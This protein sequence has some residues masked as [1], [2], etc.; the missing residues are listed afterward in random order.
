MIFARQSETIWL[1]CYFPGMVLHSFSPLT[2][3]VLAL[4]SIKISTREH[5]HLCELSQLQFLVI[6][7][8]D[9]MIQQGSFPKLKRIVEHVQQG[10]CELAKKAGEDAQFGDGI[11]TIPADELARQLQ[12]FAVPEGFEVARASRLSL[13]TAENGDEEEDEDED[14]SKFLGLPGEANVKMISA[15]LLKEVKRLRKEESPNYGERH[16]ENEDDANSENAEEE[17]EPFEEDVDEKDEGDEEEEE[18]E[19]SDDEESDE[20]KEEEESGCFPSVHRQ[21]FVYSATLTLPVTANFKGGRKRQRTTDDI[22]STISE[23]V[24]RS[25]TPGNRTKVVDLSFKE[26]PTASKL[27]QSSTRKNEKGAEPPKVKNLRLPP[28]L[29][30]QEIKCVKLHK[31]S[32]LY[33]Y[34]MATPEGTAGSALVFCNS[35]AAV[36]RVGALLTKLRLETRM[37]HAQMQQVRANHSFYQ[38]IVQSAVRK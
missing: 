8:V 14:M 18:E 9:R 36:K 24:E 4:L 22:D 19:G 21:V 12:T 2:L 3:L 31:D 7:E 37:L 29:K 20:G 34:L 35:I 33:T 28:G 5:E 11:E 16:D 27:S 26:P 10:G 6:D 17:T 23:I 13:T 32:H 30:L 38:S 25:S 15:D 1:L